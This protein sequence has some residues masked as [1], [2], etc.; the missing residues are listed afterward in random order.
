[1][2]TRATTRHHATQ[3]NQ[4]IAEF[5]RTHAAPDLA[6]ANA[7]LHANRPQIIAATYRSLTKK[8]ANATQKV[9]QEAQTK[10]IVTDIRSNLK[11]IKT[12]LTDNHAARPEF[13]ANEYAE[14]QT[15]IADPAFLRANARTRA[16][17][18]REAAPYARFRHGNIA[19]RPTEVI[20]IPWHL[21]KAISQDVIRAIAARYETVPEMLERCRVNNIVFPEIANERSR[22]IHSPRWHIAHKLHSISIRFRY[23]TRTDEGVTEVR[24]RQL[25]ANDISLDRGTYP[26]IEQMIA[27]YC[28]ND[29]YGAD[30]YVNIAVDQVNITKNRAARAEHRALRGANE[31]H[32]SLLGDADAINTHPGQCIFDII[33]Y[34]IAT[35]KRS[36]LAYMTKDYLVQKW[37]P[38]SLE[39]G[40]EPKM[41]EQLAKD[42]RNINLTI[43]NISGHAFIRVRPEDPNHHSLDLTIVASQGHGFLV[44]DP[45]QRAKIAKS[46]RIDFE[47]TKWDATTFYNNWAIASD[48]ESALIQGT[49]K[50]A[51]IGEDRGT[52]GHPDLAMFILFPKCT[53]LKELFVKV[54]KFTH[55]A[56][57]K[58][59]PHSGNVV[60]FTHP[61][62]KQV[63][64]VADEFE[65]RKRT[66]DIMEINFCNQSWAVLVQ[67]FYERKIGTPE[68]ISAYSP[69]MLETHQ[70]FPV[71]PIIRKF[72]FPRKNGTILE[73]EEL[74]SYTLHSLDYKKC[75]SHI[76]ASKAGRKCPVFRVMDAIL[77]YDQKSKIAP[78]SRYFINRNFEMERLLIEKKGWYFG[79][80][81]Q[82]CLDRKYISIR[83]IT[84]VQK[85]YAVIDD[86][87][88]FVEKVYETFPVNEAKLL[89]NAW[90]GLQGRNCRKSEWAVYTPDEE[91]AECLK[92]HYKQVG[93]ERGL[94]GKFLKESIQIDHKTD[95]YF[96]RM[97]EQIPLNY[98]NVP[99][100]QTVLLRAHLM[101]NQMLID[102]RAKHPN[103]IIRAIMTDNIK[104][105]LPLGTIPDFRLKTDVAIGEY[106]L[107]PIDPK[108][109]IIGKN[110]LTSEEYIDSESETPRKM[111][112]QTIEFLKTQTNSAILT[113]DPGVGKSFGISGWKQP[114][115][116]IV[117]PLC[118]N[119]DILRSKYGHAD[120]ITVTSFLFQ[121]AN[122]K[123]FAM[124]ANKYRLS[125]RQCE[126][127]IM[128]IR[129]KCKR[130]IVDEFSRVNSYEMG[131]LI[132]S[133]VPIVL[134]GDNKQG[135]A[136]ESHWIDYMTNRVVLDAVDYNIIQLTYVP[137]Q[138]RNDQR[139][140]DALQHFLKTGQLRKEDFTRPIDDTN[141]ID[142]AFQ[143]KTIDKCNAK[144]AAARDA[145]YADAYNNEEWNQYVLHNGRRFYV[146]S[147]IVAIHS[148]KKMSFYNG[149]QFTI[150]SIKGKLIE[151]KG[152]IRTIT[153]YPSTLAKFKPADARTIHNVQGDTVETRF[154]IRELD[155]PR[156]SRQLL[157]TALSRARS[158][159]Q[160]CLNWTDRVFEIEMPPTSTL[161]L[162]ILER[163]LQTCRIYRITKPF[164]NDS[165]I[166]FT[167]QTLE[168]RLQQH[169]DKPCNSKM[170]VFL[171]S[172]NA[173]I[174]LIAE[175]QFFTKQEMEAYET[176]FI[177][178]LK[179]T[180]NILKVGRPTLPKSPSEIK[181]LP[182]K[183]ITVNISESVVKATGTKQQKNCFRICWTENSVQK[184]KQFVFIDTAREKKYAEALAFKSALEARLNG[185]P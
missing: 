22:A 14:Y 71:G 65:A 168:E 143:N 182:I 72:P 177:Q 62:S 136:V 48:D 81:V 50:P 130:I 64:M 150:T 75:Y 69:A 147:P 35:Q 76:L 124:N 21:P 100:Y 41:V 116:I 109:P 160:I 131:L 74:K 85:P 94:G 123:D 165:Y 10:Q 172:G 117:T 146:N 169:Y 6:A 142:L 19:R 155:H 120:T 127:A 156:M 68:E 173:E 170:R 86:I 97:I 159:D 7:Y 108:K 164:S 174:E 140:Y 184:R 129:L 185:D 128:N 66:C 125:P 78:L 166:G 12:S 158:L 11:N 113:A 15:R 9:A 13:R 111:K 95:M 121:M 32:F 112:Q 99:F 84:Q 79:F 67:T 33:L 1:M 87:G 16:A 29:R 162:K 51:P 58:C 23:V 3:T 161:K 179:P 43:L 102:I 83:D 103:A 106:G 2:A 114:E 180:L 98:G 26:V 132:Q 163:Q 54:A 135:H 178:M 176:T 122:L 88:N 101:I 27:D 38:E 63:Y 61:I 152:A 144:K 167:T 157:F 141:P 105:Y 133:G 25:S 17:I 107:E 55:E 118:P 31:W 53:N 52:L 139:L 154:N 44:T 134:I 46:G 45:K 30:S 49:F 93:L 110:E 145:L 171:K 36:R 77:P 181:P 73:E 151:L 92:N 89:V 175:D 34:A 91:E 82:E 8:I 39:K 149:Q 153:I 42:E 47:S 115:D 4:I 18:I 28:T 5:K 80:F 119:M 126:R 183:R 70:E 60:E 148:C 40:V 20:D 90:N 56:G 24:S 57:M 137:G 59:T 104:F 96:L 138:S 37:G